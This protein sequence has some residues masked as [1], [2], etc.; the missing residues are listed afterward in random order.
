MD[1]DFKKGVYLV[2]SV[3]NVRQAVWNHFTY[4]NQLR[5]KGPHKLDKGLISVSR[6]TKICLQPYLDPFYLR[7]KEGQSS[8]QEKGQAWHH[9]AGEG[10]GVCGY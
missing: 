9:V 10:G 5:G 1:C 4:L 2:Q 3:C 6:N 8:L 7:E